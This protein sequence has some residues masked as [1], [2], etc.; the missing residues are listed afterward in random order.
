MILEIER[1]FVVNK[2]PEHLLAGAQKV[3]IQQGYLILNKAKELRVRSK[4]KQYFLTEKKGSGLCREETETEITREVFK[5][6]WPLT[7]GNRV[8]KTRYTFML[9]GYQHEL[10]VYKGAL[11]PLIILEVEFESTE[12]AVKFPIPEF[13]SQDVTEDPRY[14]NSF[15]AKQSV[16]K[17]VS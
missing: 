3:Q 14:K 9:N 15:L 8:K 7:K 11:K 1:K 12:K 17:H 13:A 6:L 10:D 2:L 4:N 16:L 5:L